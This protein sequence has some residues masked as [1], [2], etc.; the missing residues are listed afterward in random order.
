VSALQIAGPHDAAW[1]TWRRHFEHF[2]DDLA[3][4]LR[5]ENEML[6]PRALELEQA[7]S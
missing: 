3:A 1:T 4:G 5:L 2:G 6:F 7:L